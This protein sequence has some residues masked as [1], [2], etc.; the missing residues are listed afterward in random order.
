MLD[1]ITFRL[2]KMYA[3]KVYNLVFFFNCIYKVVQLSPQSNPGTVSS[4]HEEPHS[5]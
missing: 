3:L 5:R 4:P 2:H 1:S